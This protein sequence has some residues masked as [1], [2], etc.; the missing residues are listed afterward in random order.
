VPKLATS[1]F[2]KD[3]ILHKSIFFP[4]LLLSFTAFCSMASTETTPAPDFTIKHEQ[5]PASLS[6]LEGQVVYLDFWASWC[7]PCRKSFPWMNRM[8]AKYS[9]QD[10]QIIA[11]NLDAESDMA[12]TF[13][14]KVPADIPII[15]DPEGQIA[16]DYKLVGMPSSYMIDKKG[17]VRIVHKGFFSDKEN[18]YEQELQ[19]LLNESE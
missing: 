5:L 18:Q 19:S 1:I 4:T 7:K 17:Q 13:L 9:T 10:L 2:L 16:L 3:V 12:Q 8:Q 14:D 15:Y 11:I 6:E